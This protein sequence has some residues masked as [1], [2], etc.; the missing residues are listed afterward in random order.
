MKTNWAEQN[1]QV[2]RILMERSAIYQ[3]ALGPI[4]CWVG[5]VAWVSA[6]LG[7]WW[8][9]KQFILHWLGTGLVAVV[10]AFGLARRQA[11]R[12]HE[13]FWSPPAQRVAQALLP[14]LVAAVVITGTTWRGKELWQIPMVGLWAVLY[15]CALHSAG[16]FAP[17]GLRTLGK[18]FL[19]A[20]LSWL[21]LLQLQGKAVLPLHAAM[22]IIFGG[23]HLG[24]AFYLSVT[25][26]ES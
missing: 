13:A 1:L 22:G 2:I 11:R 25:K 19:A 7:L 10:G 17:R 9:E 21:C 26:R 4:M 24:Y 5:G 8:G 20:G 3:R 14:P 12:D 23:L 15:G 6:S 16:F 18:L